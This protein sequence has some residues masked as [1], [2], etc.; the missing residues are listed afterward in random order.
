MRARIETLAN[1]L[2][3]VLRETAAA[4]VV[5]FQM[6]VG[7]G[8]AD[9]RD[10]EAG[11]A[12][13]LEH[14]LFKG[15]ARRGVGEIAQD[16]ERAGGYINAW[17]S[18]D[19]TV[20]HITMASRFLDQGLDVLADAIQHAALDGQELARELTVIRE[21]I[22]M[23]RD[24]PARMTTEGL[25]GAMFRKHPYGR[26]VIG[27]DRTV[28]SFD[29]RLVS[30]FYR[31]WY[32]P[33]NM[34]L[35]VAGDFDAERMTTKVTR[36][37]ADFDGRGV[38]RRSTRLAEPA[39]R[40]SRLVQRAYPVSES[41]LALGFPIPGMT[42]DDVPALDL[43]AA[44]LGQ[45]AS[46]RLETRVRREQGLATEIRAM[47][48]TPKDAG[49][50]GVYGMVPP[51]KLAAAVEAVTVELERVVEEAIP[52]REIEKA[53]SLLLS[54]S[55]YSEETVDGVARKLGYYALHCGDVNF[56]DRYMAG[57]VAAQA[58]DLSEIAARYLAPS[59]AS[60]SVIVPDPQHRPLERKVSWIKGRG[61][62]ARVEEKL[63][64]RELIGALEGRWKGR[65]G[66]P[67]RAATKPA[68]TVQ[69]LS[70]GDTLIVRPDPGARIA[71]AR[72]A[73]LGG[74]R[75][76]PRTKSGIISLL[77]NTLTRG[78]AR[79]TAAEVA[80]AL[81]A[82]AC[83]VGG[84]GGRNTIGVHGEFLAQRFAEGFELFADCLRRP[85]FD[86]A[87]VARERELLIEEVR[88]SADH[89]DRR[90]FELFQARLFGRHPY[91]RSILGTEETVAALEPRDLRRFLNRVTGAGQMVLAVVGGVDPDEVVEL[92]ERLLVP[93]AGKGR[94][95]K[96]PAP[97]K[98][99]KGPVQVTE[100][101]PKEQ[102]H[103][104]LGFPGVA[105]DDADRFAVDVLTEILG[106]HGGRLF[107]S[108]REERGLAYAVTALSMEGI[109]PGYVALYTGTSPGQEREVVA[110]MRRELERITT[111]R[112][113]RA[114]LDRVKQH[115]I[116]TRA[117]SRQRSAARAAGMALGQ[118][119]GLGHDADVRYPREVEQVTATR[120]VDVAR[121]LFDPQ[122]MV[123][124]CIGPDADRLDLLEASD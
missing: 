82:Q 69:R 90:A 119:Y 17:T 48:Y 8:S 1:G 30:A 74:L 44:V 107:A 94:P 13:V 96:D 19:E 68:T 49:V 24:N 80:L 2:T 98:P 109:E 64:E 70:S 32:V 84:F 92:A 12:H 86:P 16:V 23:G 102:S 47:A 40:R 78:T 122:R 77:A 3:V 54:D 26:P 28:R 124:S 39:Q 25:F 101:A 52:P 45:G 104:V 79:M 53:R 99:L 91:G 63:L 43:L 73:F 7:V 6:W 21:E 29:R 9:E 38:P 72:A 114:E 62:R 4:P 56:E 81:D 57:L 10:H 108:L 66:K 20:F 35:V 14:M 93:G 60:V 87:E 36:A 95:P 105:L 88:A 117:I 33:K 11:L 103:V 42:H 111:A 37:F 5:T 15:T 59:R 89:L 106:G 46:S 76:E 61:R 116:G 121:R 71:A 113:A 67:R 120:V 85:A 31:R 18:H 75:R 58:A 115:L 27:Y 100:S 97:W 65:V 22:R 110:A 51:H 118:L 123:L 41:N 112:P 55:H 50:F 34:V 83:S